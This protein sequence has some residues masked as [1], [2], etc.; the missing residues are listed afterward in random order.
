MIDLVSKDQIDFS[1]MRYGSLSY[2]I[3][4]SLD[5]LANM[6][7][8]KIRKYALMIHESGYFI[9]WQFKDPVL[10]IVKEA[11]LVAN[12]NRKARN[13][14]EASIAASEN[15]EAKILPEI[16]PPRVRIFLVDCDSNLDVLDEAQ[17]AMTKFTNDI[18]ESFVKRT[19]AV[20]A[21]VEK[22]IADKEIEVNDK[23]KEIAKRKRAII[24][25]L[26]KKVSDADGV[27]GWFSMTDSIKHALK[28]SLKLF[29]AELSA[30]KQVAMLG[31]TALKQEQIPNRT[32]D[33]EVLFGQ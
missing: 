10:E 19:A 8:S 15:R 5:D 18:T 28:A 29:D 14:K 9:P 11:V 20:V 17:D 24:N 6:I 23:S 13:A 22:A 26:K 33:E 7:R 1:K 25:D 27:F 12:E 21:H 3:P 16:T 4:K 30:L 2:D 32:E 31:D